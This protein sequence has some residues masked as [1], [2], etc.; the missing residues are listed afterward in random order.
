MILSVILALVI[1][2]INV[3]SI[4]TEGLSLVIFMPKLI[5]YL[6]KECNEGE[7]RPFQAE[8]QWYQLCVNGTYS[9]RRCSSIG[10]AQQQMFNPLTKTCTD[11]FKL[12]ID[13]Q[14]QSYRQCLIIES[15]SPFGKWIVESCGSGKHFDQISKKCI[16][17]STCGE[18]FKVLFLKLLRVISLK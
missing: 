15:I 11:N 5:F 1:L 6:I 8:C 16:E 2:N 9:A 18:F 17:S 4:A 13:G 10:S 7:R 3:S 12:P 14:C